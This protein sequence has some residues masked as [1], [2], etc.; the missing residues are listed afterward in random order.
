MPLDVVLSH[1]YKKEHQ[2]ILKEDMQF[3]CATF[4][5]IECFYVLKN[6]RQMTFSSTIIATV[7]RKRGI[8]PPNPEIVLSQLPSDRA[9]TPEPDKKWGKNW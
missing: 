6:I 9:A 3:C 4:D 2:D 7:F 5:S 1:F 8:C